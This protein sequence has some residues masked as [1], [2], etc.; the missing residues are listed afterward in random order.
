MKNQAHMKYDEADL[1]VLQN[2]GRFDANESVFFARQLEFI[3]SRTYDVKRAVLSAFV[4]MPVST[5]IPEG[6]TTHTYRQFDTVGMAKVIAN[7]ANDLPR[8]DVTGKEFTGPIRSIGNS[9]G[10]NV[11]EIRSAM[12]AGVPLSSRKAM[13]ATRAHQEKINEL[14]FRGDVESGLPGF[15]TN[16]NIPEVTLLADGTAASKTFTSKSADK[17]VRDV[18]SL[19]NKIIVQSK[20]IHRGTEVWLPIAQYALIATTQNS[21]ASDTTI[22]S[23]LQQVHP[24]VTFRSVVEMTGAGAG[25][26]DRMYA[27]ENSIEN[28][29]L[30][31]P[32][33]IRQYSP[34][35][36]GL[37]F[38]IPV[39]SRFAGVTVPYPLAFTFADG[40]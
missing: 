14:A 13:A 7:Y 18:N 35:Q 40:I 21:T 27:M 30:D 20:G 34:Q 23:F 16:P 22:L 31:I 19:I 6:A 8:A 29:Q 37:E 5:E 3:K 32:M 26:T 24:G 12:F 28:W 25:A 1:R 11:Q 17:I 33:M 15:L 39:E 2:S 36:R 9:Y 4:I 10:Y 38:E